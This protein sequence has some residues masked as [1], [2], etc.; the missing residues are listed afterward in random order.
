MTGGTGYALAALACYGVGDF[1]YKRATAEGVQAHHFLMGQAWCFAPAIVLYGLATGTLVLRT[2]AVW[3]GLAGLFMFIGLFNFLR[4]LASGP[5][6]IAAPIFRLNFVVTSVLAILVLGEPLTPA[7]PIALV[8]ALVATW[9][10]LG[11]G[12]GAR[13]AKLD[14]GW[15]LTVLIATLS[16]GAGNF[17]HALGIRHGST[18]ETALS[19][20]A[21]VFV[22]LATIFVRMTDG[23]IAP[24]PAMWKH[25]VAAATV[26]MGAFLLMLYGLTLGPASVL[27]PITQMGFVVT[28]ALGIALLGEPL[29]VR[30]TVGL[31]AAVGTLAALAF[32]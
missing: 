8:L 27:V 16:L 10:L 9:L 25:T 17:F 20:Q 12:E 26:L 5:V 7:M 32:A 24:P 14:G 23:Q 3:N 31:V 4:S 29:T 19:A 22:A 2:S 11:G 13:Q 21:I 28:A 1:I 18:P 30:K 6:S 15:L